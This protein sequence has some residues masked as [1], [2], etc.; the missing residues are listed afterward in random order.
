MKIV[1]EIGLIELMFFAGLQVDWRELKKMTDPVFHL[2]GWLF[3]VTAVGVTIVTKLFVSRWAEAIGLGA[4]M[5]AMGPGISGYHLY[6]M[7]SPAS[8]V[9]TLVMGVAVLSGAS[10]ILL[11]IAG[12]ATQYSVMHGVINM[13]I[14]VAWFL[15]K[16]IMFFAAAYFLMSRFLRLTS[17]I[18]FEKR[19][20][21][22][23]AGY[24]ILVA[25]LYAWA[26]MHFG[27]F[28]AVG[29][30]F[31]GGGLLMGAAPVLKEEIEERLASGL[32]SLFIGVFFL[33]L[34]MEFN[35]KGMNGRFSFVIA[36]CGAVVGAKLLGNWAATR[37]PFPDQPPTAGVLAAMLPPG[38]MGVL[39]AA[40]L[41]SR[42]ILEP[43]SFNG[44]MAVVVGLTAL[45]PLFLRSVRKRLAGPEPQSATATSSSVCL[46]GRRQRPIRC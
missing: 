21:Q 41:F 37:K 4:I 44:A 34:G 12:Q 39:I 14:A 5:A 25:A 3:I 20:V 1:A 42:G 30:A 16:L 15:G 35:L 7:K 2:M 46:P 43:I 13:S 28:A 8:K 19:P 26:A 31:I 38:E 10:A 18:R 32:G 9:S 36:L 40:Y 6:E 17:G 27:S 23:L 29:V 11:M 22:K 24:L 45:A 33:A